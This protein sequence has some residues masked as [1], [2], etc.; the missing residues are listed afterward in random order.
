MSSFT[1]HTSRVREIDPYDNDPYYSRPL[2]RST[3]KRQRIDIYDDDHDDYPY[4]SSHAKSQALTIRQPSQLEKYNVWSYPKDS[5][6]HRHHRHDSH[7]PSDDD[8]EDDSRTIRY[9][10]IT[11]RPSYSRHHSPIRSDPE[12]DRDR[13]Y[14]LKVK[15][16]FT[17]PKS[18]HGASSSSTQ[19]AMHWPGDMF[20]RREKFED[21]RWETR[22]KERGEVWWD[23]ER[24]ASREKTVRYRKVKRTRTDEWKPLSGFRRL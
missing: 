17:R 7:A 21:E 20:K 19:K 14:Q 22:E 9:K 24:P 16:T 4:S 12:E 5:H 11:V 10:C 3:S 15:A 8:D 13:E 2:T 1:Y 6:S 18:S 23:E